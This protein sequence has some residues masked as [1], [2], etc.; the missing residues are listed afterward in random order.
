MC[1]RRDVLMIALLLFTAV[2]LLL[3]FTPSIHLLQ[4][5]A[6]VHILGLNINCLAII[7][8]WNLAGRLSWLFFTILHAIFKAFYSTT[9]VLT[10]VT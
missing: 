10:D 3:L 9:Q 7:L 2:L 1:V 4:A 8:R 6:S 5:L